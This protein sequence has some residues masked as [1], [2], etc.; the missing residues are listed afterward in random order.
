MTR[1]YLGSLV[2]PRTGPPR[3]SK[4]AVRH[5]GE[6]AQEARAHHHG[7]GEG[8]PDLRRGQRA[9]ARDIVSSDQIDDWLSACSATRA[10][11]SSTRPSQVKVAGQGRR[12]RRGERRGASQGARSTAEKEEPRGRGGGRDGYSQDQRPGAHVPAQDGLGLAAHPRGR[13]RDRQAHRGGRAARAAGRAQLV[14]RDRGDPRARRQAA[15]AARSASRRSSRTPTRR[16]PSSTSSGTSSASAR[17]S[18]RSAS[19]ATSRRRS[20]RSWPRKAVSEA[21]AQ[22]AAR[23]RSRTCK[24]E[25]LEALQEMRLNKKQIDEIVLKL[26]ELVVAHRAGRTARS[27]T[28]STRSG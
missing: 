2:R 24:H 1:P 18:T 23:S 13:G 27:P 26:K 12:R 20:P 15:E 3:Q 19:S 6:R 11:R 8:L 9:H 21:D 10:S 5:Q 4:S 25:I 28:A 7:Q 17:S 14:G 22:E 16:T